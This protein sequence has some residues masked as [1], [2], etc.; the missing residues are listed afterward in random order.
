MRAGART[1]AHWRVG[2]RTSTP[3]RERA[4][5]QTNKDCRKHGFPFFYLQMEACSNNSKIVS[6]TNK[7]PPHERVGPIGCLR[8]NSKMHT[9]STCHEHF[10]KREKCKPMKIK[11][12]SCSISRDVFATLLRNCSRPSMNAA[13]DLA[14]DGSGNS[15]CVC[16]HA[17]VYLWIHT[18]MHKHARECRC[19][20]MSVRGTH[21]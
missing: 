9:K 6:L 10:A 17:Y 18:C 20:C 1:A 19:V 16:E 15:R 8:C 21:V 2:S 5:T 14:D 7:A 4:D 11:L 13:D 3:A 12:H